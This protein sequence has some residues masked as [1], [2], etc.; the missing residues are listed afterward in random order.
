MTSKIILPAGAGKTVDLKR[1]LGLGKP[2]SIN[3]LRGLPPSKPL[4]G[5][6][7]EQITVPAKHFEA[8]IRTNGMLRTYATLLNQHMNWHTKQP[9]MKT[10]DCLRCCALNRMIQDFK[11]DLT[12]D[13]MELL[14]EELERQELLRTQ[15]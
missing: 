12:E 13:G 4:V 3:Q 11:P 10:K 6:A 14:L 15:H 2:Q 1:E 5:E 7:E 8:M 9:A